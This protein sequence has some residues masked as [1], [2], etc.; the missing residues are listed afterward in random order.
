M[1]LQW[2]YYKTLRSM[3]KLP[4]VLKGITNVHEARD[5]VANGV[6][7]IYLSNHGGRQLETSPSALEVAHEIYL[8]APEIF[9]QV[10]VYADGGVRYGSDIL[11]LLA[12]GV[13]AVGLGRPF[14]FANVFGVDGVQRAIQLLRNEVSRDASN[15]GLA[16]LKA[17][18]TTWVWLRNSLD[19]TFV[20]FL[21]SLSNTDFAAADS[22]GTEC[23]G[24]I[25]LIRQP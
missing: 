18:N 8:Q 6:P 10:E 20:L 17:L 4:I 11:K 7:A 1:P 15:L 25:H 16:D 21:S 9:R 19:L 2:E 14:M 3:T 13:R 12:F 22:N 23:L 5:A 24:R